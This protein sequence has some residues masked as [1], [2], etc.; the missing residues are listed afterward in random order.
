MSF[1]LLIT[2]VFP[3]VIVIYA[4]VSFVAPDWVLFNDAYMVW[5]GR[6]AGL[7]TI[8]IF[9]IVKVWYYAGGYY[10]SSPM[11]TALITLAS[12][13]QAAICARI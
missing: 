4:I 13:G 11:R 2:R 8:L 3:V 1:R 10:M 7:L 6:F 12:R 9:I 5:I